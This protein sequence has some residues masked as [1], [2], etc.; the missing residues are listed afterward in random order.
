MSTMSLRVG[1]IFASI[2]AAKSAVAHAIIDAGDSYRVLEST[3]LLYILA[4]KTGKEC[5]FYV[6]VTLNK[7]GIVSIRVSTIVQRL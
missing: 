4:C 2:E 1:D 6:R 5:T 3:K 7:K